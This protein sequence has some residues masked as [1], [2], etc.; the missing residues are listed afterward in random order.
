MMSLAMA[1]WP[2]LHA[3]PTPR[4]LWAPAGF[5]REIGPQPPADRHICVTSLGTAGQ[6]PGRPTSRWPMR[7][8]LSGR[9]AWPRVGE[10]PIVDIACG[11][12][13]NNSALKTKG[14]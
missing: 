9:F 12:R 2:L 8:I 14:D 7:M 6:R 11:T 1:G 5:A 4:G 3:A 13:V 10:K